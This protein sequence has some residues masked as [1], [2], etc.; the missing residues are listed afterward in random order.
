MTRGAI[1]VLAVLSAM[2]AAARDGSAHKAYILRCAGCHGM[3]GEGTIPGGVPAFPGSIGAIAR[4]ETGRTYMLHVP[5]VGSASLDDAEI[6][7]VMNYILDAWSD[8]TAPPFTASEVAR[9]R[10]EPVADVV[11]ERRDLVRELR[12]EGIAIA[13][14]PWP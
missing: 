6:A 2:P 7:G 10:A 8:G 3:T 1:I 14:Y 13:E 11:A 4:N 5:G 12:S 9:R